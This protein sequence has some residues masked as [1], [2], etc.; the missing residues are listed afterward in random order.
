MSEWTLA[1]LT[2]VTLVSDD[3]YGEDEEDEDELNGALYFKGFEDLVSEIFG[4]YL[5]ISTVQ[6]CV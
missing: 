1:D 2:N 5:Q 6:F 4:Y 3:T